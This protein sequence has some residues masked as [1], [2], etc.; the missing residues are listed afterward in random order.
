MNMT[1]LGKIFTIDHTVVL[2]VPVTGDDEEIGY[3][4]NVVQ[5]KLGLR[6]E[7]II[8]MLIRNEGWIKIIW[9]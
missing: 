6:S 3:I 2:I 5:E 8:D 9:N 4:F 7:F 1:E